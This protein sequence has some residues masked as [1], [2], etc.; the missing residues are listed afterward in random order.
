MLYC[1]P[2]HYKCMGYTV[3]LCDSNYENN[4]DIAIADIS[5]ERDNINSGCVYSDI[6]NIQQNL[7]F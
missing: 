1:N 5:I 3:D 6:N 2:D 4:F 7:T